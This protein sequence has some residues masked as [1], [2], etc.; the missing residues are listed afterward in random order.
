[1]ALLATLVVVVMITWLAL[2]LHHVALGAQ[3]RS[4]ARRDAVV[5]ASAADA[6]L[7]GVLRDGGALGL[8]TLGV[9]A[10]PVVVRRTAGSAMV[11]VRAFRAA[12][13]TWELVATAWFPDSLLARRAVRTS[14]LTIRLDIPDVGGLAALTVRDAVRVTGSGEVVGTDTAT[15]P[16][17]LTCQPGAG[18]AGVA[19]P[20]TTQ[21]S[22]GGRVVGLPALLELPA[23]GTMAPYNAYGGES[24]RSLVARAQVHLPPGSVITPGP[25]VTP[26]ACDTL[27]S[28][29]WGEP[30]G[31]GPCRRHA[32]IV[33]AAGS[34]DL[35]GGRG[36]GI[37]LVDGDL[38]V[39]QGARFDGVIVVRDDVRTGPGGGLLRGAVLAADTLIGAGDHSQVGDG[40]RVERAECIA[41]GVLSRQ[42][43][44]RPVRGRGWAPM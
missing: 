44:W 32:P 29:N 21:R 17:A 5:A 36:Q 13:A 4:A 9:A 33:H 38:T 34:I 22:G 16:L 30:R 18:V 35:R 6:G 26:G 10:P 20:D 42:A 11:E 37:L 14:T 3:R 28:T 12:P 41:L 24:W 40:L 23:V 1:M 43:V 25:L 7:W 19:M 31:T 8:D 27:P 2:A 39:S 15:S